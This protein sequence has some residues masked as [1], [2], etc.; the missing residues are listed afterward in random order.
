MHLKGSIYYMACIFDCIYL[1]RCNTVHYNMTCL[2]YGKLK[3]QNKS[4]KSWH[5]ENKNRTQN[6]TEP[7]LILSEQ[8]V[9]FCQHT[10]WR[11]SVFFKRQ[12]RYVWKRKVRGRWLAYKQP[13]YHHVI[14]FNLSLVLKNSQT[15]AHPLPLIPT[16]QSVYPRVC[17]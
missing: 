9:M 10:Y 3:K 17:V 15:S 4:R 2:H 1:Y 11:G 14:V 12:S 6:K 7:L 16:I 13:L 8:Y 5:G